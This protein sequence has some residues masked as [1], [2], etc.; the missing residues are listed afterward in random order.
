LLSRV[1]RTGALAAAVAVA[2][3]VALGPLSR[4]T[5]A[6]GN[7]YD[8]M[9]GVGLTASAVTVPWTQGLLD[10][11]N[12]PLTSAGNEPSPNADRSSA[13]PAS[14]LSFMYPDFKS[15]K[16]T[17][18]QTQN[19]GHQGITVRWTGG[20]PT[21]EV[22]QI[23]ANFLQMMECY[24]D[25][26]SGPDPADCEY[27]SV[28][29]LGGGGGIA[30]AAIGSR[31]GD[32]CTTGSAPSTADPP[33]SLNGDTA[34][35]GCD[36]LEPTDASHIAPCPGSDCT[37]GQDFSVPFVPVGD[38]THP[39][40]GAVDET[41][42][43]NEFNTDEVQ[44]A[45]TSAAG[46]GQQQ[47]ETLTGT[48]AP[49][50]GCGDPEA[51]GQARGCWLVIVP[52][53]QYE[54]N[55]YKLNGFTGTKAELDTSPLSAAN[56]AQR[57]QVHLSFAP[58]QS[59]CPIGT[60]ERETVGTQIVSRAMQSW[61]L[62]LN[63]AANCTKIYGY[64]AVPE[65]TSTEQLSSPGGNVGLAFTTVPI[66]SEAA[67]NSSG[68]AGAPGVPPL[69]YAPV[70]ISA[71]DFGFNINDGSGYITNAVELTPEL[72][73]RSLT[74]SYR[75]DLPDYYP[76]AFGHNGPAWS[77]ANPTNISNDPAFQLHNGEVAPY[78]KSTVSLAPLL[79]EDHSGLNQQVWRWIQADAP[80]SAWLDGTAGSVAIDPGYRA[81]KL[82]KAP[83]IDSYPRAYTG[84]LD[85]GQW[86]GP[87]VK[88]E[89]KCSLDLLPYA[90]NFDSAA[91]AVLAANNPTAGGWDTTARAPDGTTGWW[92]KNGAEPPG[93][94]FMWAADDTPDLAAYGLVAAQLCNDSASTCVGPTT[95]SVSTALKTAVPDSA[96][97]LQ[98]NPAKPGN[99]GYPLVDVTYAAVPTKQSAAAL[100]D[101]ADLIAYAAGAGQ[102]PGSAPGDL[103][104][105]YLPLP[106]SLQA[107][108]RAV[109]T[110][111][112]ALAGPSG[113]RSA[114]P[115]PS[116]PGGNGQPGAAPGSTPRGST[117]AA[118]PG[119]TASS[120]AG[121]VTSLPSAALAAGTTSRQPVGTIR[122]ALVAVVIAG[123]ACATGGVL[124]RSA[125]VPRWLRL[126]RVRP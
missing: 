15:L 50:L 54:P 7:S 79:T 121:P 117:S 22:G 107:Q 98:V 96:G 99:G 108:A 16:V 69:V 111:L 66:G 124:L 87:P 39:V 70:A 125:R 21:A 19:I 86:P 64:S 9:T 30:P 38:P 91:A 27:G 101:Y 122:W 40:Y 119:G 100:N 29:M 71:L 68:G 4:A 36:P 97:L 73:A 93:Q 45:V 49:G 24:G 90:D 26:D 33:A 42:Y 83:A 5:A 41:Q 88:E 60:K 80:A 43:Y 120:P 32:L 51:N 58:V 25:S 89:I 14:A 72:L 94:T 46:T 102:T 85:L 74:Q 34:V 113:T 56:W 76:S 84:C 53:G 31:E 115:P 10:A 105:G 20:E 59:F 13:S 35:A 95:A 48:Q 37:S 47:F 103:P 18:S 82:G 3:L 63:H 81:L 17:V 62:A 116:A 11:S 55:G 67:R 106:A 28:G 104:P 2:A 52:R 23:Q 118:A 109:V 1:Q 110:R 75:T 114:T 126:R 92:G 65:A 112:R 44:V 12:Q 57:I 123:L 78:N 6:T 77:L 61:Q 8:Q